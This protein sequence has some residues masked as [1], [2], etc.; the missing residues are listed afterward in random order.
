MELEQISKELKMLKV[1]QKEYT[2]DLIE[3]SKWQDMIRFRDTCMGNFSYIVGK[4]IAVYYIIRLGLSIKQIIQ[5]NYGDEMIGKYLRY[6]LAALGL[7]K[8]N[9][10]ATVDGVSED[11]AVT[12]SI[13]LMQLF[14]VAVLIVINIQGFLRKLLVTLKN[15]MRDNEIQISY[16]NTLLVFSFIMGAYYLSILLQMSKNLPVEQRK[17]FE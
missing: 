5:P 16:N 11:L 12:L 3:F 2:L 7:L 6:F 13:Q 10:S 1:L 8:T 15:I 17:P 14:I 9:E 4:F